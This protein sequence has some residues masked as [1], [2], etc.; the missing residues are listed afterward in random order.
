[1]SLLLIG[2]ALKSGVRKTVDFSFCSGAKIVSTTHINTNFKVY[3]LFELFKLTV[4]S[5]F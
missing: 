5:V 4:E 1:M 2:C 3:L